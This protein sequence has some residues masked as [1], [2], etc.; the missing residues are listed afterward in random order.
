MVRSK[1]PN[2]LSRRLLSRGR[3]FSCQSTHILGGP[4]DED[5]SFLVSI[6]GH[7][8]YGSLVIK[9]VERLV[10]NAARARNLRQAHA[11]SWI[12]GSSTIPLKP[13]SFGEY[14]PSQLASKAARGRSRLALRFCSSQFG[15]LFFATESAMYTRAFYKHL[16]YH[17][18]LSYMLNRSLLL[19]PSENP[20][21]L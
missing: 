5:C 4:H 2:T 20:F 6:L 8:A 18:R 19:S 12:V 11:E 9:C 15:W 21:Y 13:S 7:P 1:H 14:V 16:T 3:L 10:V 17:W